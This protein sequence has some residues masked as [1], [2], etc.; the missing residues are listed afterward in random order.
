MI[1]HPKRFDRTHSIQHNESNGNT[2]QNRK[3]R[4]KQFSQIDIS[5]DLIMILDKNAPLS[6]DKCFLYLRIRL[7]IIINISINI[8]LQKPS[9]ARIR[10]T[11]RFPFKF[12]RINLEERTSYHD[13]Y[14][15]IRINAN[16]PSA[17][18]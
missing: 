11:P 6:T 3:P 15:N 7:D 1:S 17:N 14:R 2:T 16:K 8:F 4:L 9:L 18:N 5:L 13:P 10:Q 12:L